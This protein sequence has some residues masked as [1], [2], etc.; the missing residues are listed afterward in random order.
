MVYATV[1][2]QS[3]LAGDVK[4]SEVRILWSGDAPCGILSDVHSAKKKSRSVDSIWTRVS[5]KVNSVSV[6]HDS[7]VVGNSFGRKKILQSYFA[8]KL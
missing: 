6:M 7:S 1:Y 4:V 8:T 3:Q 2:T 5:A